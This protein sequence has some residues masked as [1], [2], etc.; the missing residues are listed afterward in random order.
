MRPYLQSPVFSWN[1]QQNNC[2]LQSQSSALRI[3]LMLHVSCIVN[4][5][6]VIQIDQNNSLDSPWILIN[7]LK[8]HFGDYARKLVFVRER[9]KL[10]RYFGRRRSPQQHWWMILN[11]QISVDHFTAIKLLWGDLPRLAKDYG[12]FILIMR[13]SKPNFQKWICLKTKN[14]ARK[15]FQCEVNLLQ[16]VTA[17]HR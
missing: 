1:Q 17:R 11:F 6:L 13:W 12:L 5:S 4:I 15:T 8:S 16:W 9:N 7:K 14:S 3:Y 10:H 2:R